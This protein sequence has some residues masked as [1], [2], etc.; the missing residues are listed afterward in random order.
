MELVA[1][2]EIPLSELL[3]AAKPGISTG[4]PPCLTEEDKDHLVSVVKR[5][6]TTKHM[7][8]IEIQEEAGFGNVSTATVLKALH[9]QG[10]KAY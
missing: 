4:R 3:A 5:D 10:I 6:W 7:S 8:L 1:E 9:E 2:K